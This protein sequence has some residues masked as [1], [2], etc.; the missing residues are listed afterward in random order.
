VQY[1]DIRTLQPEQI[2][3][4]RSSS[5]QN[6]HRVSCTLATIVARGCMHIIRRV[7]LM[8]TVVA[9]TSPMVVVL[10]LIGM[11]ILHK[12]LARQRLIREQRRSL[13]PR[14]RSGTCINTSGSRSRERWRRWNICR[15]KSSDCW[16]RGHSRSGSWLRLNL[17]NV[18][19]VS[20]RLRGERTIDNVTLIPR[21][22]LA[23][24]PLGTT[25]VAELIPTAASNL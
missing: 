5:S 24:M 6:A 18:R 19:G 8:V 15:R 25:Q 14:R 23:S 13:G 4:H 21:W 2:L 9:R 7:V 3:I 22:A 17:S 16:N 1:Q 12:G 20:H 11:R 10:C